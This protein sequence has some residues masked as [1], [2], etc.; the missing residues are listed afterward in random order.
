MSPDRRPSTLDGSHGP[1][2]PADTSLEHV[3]PEDVSPALHRAALRRARIL[4]EQLPKPR[5]RGMIHLIMF[6]SAM[7]AGLVL[8]AFGGDLA[9][10]LACVVYVTTAGLLFGIS[11]TYHRGT[12]R[13]EHALMLKRFDHANIFL[14]IA[15][16]Y[17][18]LAVSLLPPRSA[19]ILLAICWT[20]AAI[21]VAFRLLWTGAPRWLYVPA[22]IA[23]GWVAIFY[24]PAFL[25]TGG[26]AVVWLLVAGGLA[27]TVGAVVYGIKRPNPSPRW[28]GFHEIFH[29]CTVGGFVCHFIAVALAIR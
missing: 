6:P 17:T 13:P 11:A 21:G 24:M 16:T 27:Y 22:Y 7:I 2:G 4:G 19:S 1:V 14:I 25:A 12:W 23:L 29:A 3:A 28:F 10:R 9:T 15:G 8:V 20:G 18:P 5:L 26:W